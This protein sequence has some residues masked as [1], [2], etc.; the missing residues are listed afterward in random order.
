LA[1]VRRR[2]AD[3]GR[4]GLRPVAR[5]EFIARVLAALAEGLRVLGP[6]HPTVLDT[7]EILVHALTQGGRF[8][9]AVVIAERA[10]ADCSRV[11]GP[12]DDR[13]RR[14]RV[15]LAEAYRL[16]GRPEDAERPG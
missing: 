5:G 4:V 6:D 3:R 15:S 1:S 13:T 7:R 8:D 10:A 14:A 11:L 2:G 16:A 9:E 12:D